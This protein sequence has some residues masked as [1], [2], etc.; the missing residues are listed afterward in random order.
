MGDNNVSDHAYVR[1]RCVSDKVNMGFSLNVGKMECL[2]CAS[3]RRSRILINEL[4]ADLCSNAIRKLKSTNVKKNVSQHFSLS[5]NFLTVT[6]KSK[7]TVLPH[8][9]MRLEEC[10][11]L[12]GSCNVPQRDTLY[13]EKQNTLISTPTI[14]NKSKPLRSSI[15]Q[16]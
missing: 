15:M 6:T 5:H 3:L 14:G 7:E 8:F 11:R 2:H 9:V 12:I 10:F 4:L 13:A 16:Y 1:K